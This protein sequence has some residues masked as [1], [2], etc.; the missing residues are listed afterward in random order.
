MLRMDPDQL[1]RLIAIEEDTQR[2]LVEA[3]AKGWQG[4]G[5]QLGDDAAAYQ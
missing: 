3:K 4:R 2:L 5:E 1:P